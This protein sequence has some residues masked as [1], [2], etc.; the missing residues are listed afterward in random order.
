LKSVREK[1]QIA[2][3]GKLIKITDFFTETLKARKA[4]NEVFQ[5]LKEN[6]FSPRSRVLYTENL[7][8]EI[9]GGIE[10]FHKKQKLKQ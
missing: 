2:Y 9:D 8:F 1:N 4:W 6:I 10:V 5:A 7:L 3:K